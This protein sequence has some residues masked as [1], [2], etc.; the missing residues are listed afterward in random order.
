MTGFANVEFFEITIRQT[1]KGLGALAGTFSRT[2]IPNF[3][4]YFPPTAKK[5][6]RGALEAAL[7]ERGEVIA[8]RSLVKKSTKRT[9]KETVRKLLGGRKRKKTI[10]K[11]RNSSYSP[12]LKSGYDM[13]APDQNSITS[14]VRTKCFHAPFSKRLSLHD[15][16]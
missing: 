11:A 4:K 8:G 5:L 16:L 1:G 3:W 15:K 13:F 7:P 6:G 10:K 12:T 14:P 9:A 2:T